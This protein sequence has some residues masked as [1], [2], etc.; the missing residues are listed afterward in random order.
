MLS[1]HFY[2]KSKNAP[3]TAQIL[4]KF[5][6]NARTACDALN[7]SITSKKKSQAEKMNVKDMENL[8]LWTQQS[9]R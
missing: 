4:E 6:G 3:Y 2:K 1:D 9:T 7:T 8:P 5:D